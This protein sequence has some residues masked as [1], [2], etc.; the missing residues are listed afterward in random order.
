MEENLNNTLLNSED[1]IPTEE[2]FSA[3]QEEIYKLRHNKEDVE[4]DYDTLI[5]NA[6]KGLD[7]DRVKS[8]RDKLKEENNH[9]DFASFFASHPE[10]TDV[11]QIPKEVIEAVAEG[12]NITTAYLRNENSRLSQRLSQIESGAKQKPAP[13][14]SESGG[15][16][17]DFLQ[18]LFG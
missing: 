11:K 9:S 14:I 13:L 2:N 16:G 5:T 12:E 4:V 15:S 6:Q 18:G 10:I 1:T 7:Y 8:Q 17:D 3:P